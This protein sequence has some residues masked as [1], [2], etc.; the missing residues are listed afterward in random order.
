MRGSYGSRQD[1]SSYSA[2]V[3]TLIFGPPNQLRA[4]SCKSHIAVKG[5]YS[6]FNGQ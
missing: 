6:A 3:N 2:T 4:P 5:R 1:A